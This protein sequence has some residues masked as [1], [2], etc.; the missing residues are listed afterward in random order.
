MN[1]DLQTCT[2]CGGQSYSSVAFLCS[3]FIALL[4]LLTVTCGVA[5]HLRALLVF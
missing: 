5:D 1:A 3:S 2:A 4:S